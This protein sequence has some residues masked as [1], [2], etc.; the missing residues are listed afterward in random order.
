M[1]LCG[2]KDVRIQ[3]NRPCKCK[4]LKP[5]SP[6]LS[7]IP[8]YAYLLL[9]LLQLWRQSLWACHWVRE[10]EIQKKSKIPDETS[11]FQSYWFHLARFVGVAKMTNIC[12]ERWPSFAKSK[13]DVNWCYMPRW[14]TKQL[15]TG[16]FEKSHWEKKPN[17]FQIFTLSKTQ[18]TKGW[19]LKTRGP[20]FSGKQI[21]REYK[22]QT[23][24]TPAEPGDSV[25]HYYRFNFHVKNLLQCSWSCHI[26]GKFLVLHWASENDVHPERCRFDWGQFFKKKIERSSLIRVKNAAEASANLPHHIYFEWSQL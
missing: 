1:W 15:V 4:K 20:D 16:I 17:W 5:F 22:M 21:G 18:N 3:T 26:S 12:W 24:Q 13:T 7:K 11:F 23:E 2:K 25:I 14:N 10:H 9:Q 8:G 19:N 6:S